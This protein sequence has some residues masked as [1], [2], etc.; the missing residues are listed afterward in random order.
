MTPISLLAAQ[1]LAAKLTSGDALAELVQSM[2]SDAKVTLLP[3]A[4]E[5]ILLSSAPVG[6]ADNN[7]QL[8]YPSVCIYSAGLKNTAIEKFRAFSGE[9]SIVAEIWASGDLISEVD[10]WIH[11]YVEVVTA[12]LRST[13]GDWGNGLSF[14]GVYEIQFQPPKIGGL[15]FVQSAKVTFDLAVSLN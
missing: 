3:I 1:T 8:T 5:Q 7:A 10:T 11:S 12:V 15:G 13:T 14:W 9:V 2:A 6:M 4:S